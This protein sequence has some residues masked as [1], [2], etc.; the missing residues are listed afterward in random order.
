MAAIVRAFVACLV[1][2]AVSLSVSTGLALGPA[3][4]F[5]ALGVMS[6]AAAA[7][8]ARGLVDGRG[9]DGGGRGEEEGRG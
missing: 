6:A 9:R 3:W 7:L 2:A 5:L 4:G 8:V 1:T